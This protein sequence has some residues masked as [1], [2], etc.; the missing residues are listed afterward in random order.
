MRDLRQFRL[1]CCGSPPRSA[2]NLRKMWIFIGSAAFAT[3]MPQGMLQNPQKTRNLEPFCC[4]RGPRKCQKNEGLQQL[5]FLV[6]EF[7]QRYSSQCGGN[8]NFHRISCFCN[9][10]PS[11]CFKINENLWFSSCS[12]SLHAESHQERLEKLRLCVYSGFFGVKISQGMPKT[13]GKIVKNGNFRQP[14]WFCTR[15]PSGSSGC[16][17]KNGPG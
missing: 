14:D 7:L 17:G 4:S 16:G 11:G 9:Q 5:Q 13:M 1:S 12:V 6:P 10:N 8:R 2:L 3:K 15:N